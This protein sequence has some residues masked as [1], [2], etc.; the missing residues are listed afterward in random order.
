MLTERTTTYNI[1]VIDKYTEIKEDTESKIEDA[2]DLLD[3]LSC[4]ELKRIKEYFDQKYEEVRRLDSNYILHDFVDDYIYV[5]YFDDGSVCQYCKGQSAYSMYKSFGV[6]LERKTKD[7]FPKYEKLMEKSPIADLYRKNEMPKKEKRKMDKSKY[8]ME[9]QKENIKQIKFTLN[10][11]TDQDIIS[12]LE[13][14]TNR[15]GYLKS[16][17]RS[18][19]KSRN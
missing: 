1:P 6:R 15:N 9:Y 17:I 4:T 12:Y 2:I 8:D 5:V 18:D 3:K 11:N 7:L 16:L 19:M 10:R 14:K 13:S